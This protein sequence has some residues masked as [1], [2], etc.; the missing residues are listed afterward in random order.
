MVLDDATDERDDVL[1]QGLPFGR[2]LL[3]VNQYW[4][5]RGRPGMI[6]FYNDGDM[7][8]IELYWLIFKSTCPGCTD[9]C[10]LDTITGL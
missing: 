5:E 3:I 9:L 2:N 6:R 7:S 1:F 10:P 8:E 4:Q